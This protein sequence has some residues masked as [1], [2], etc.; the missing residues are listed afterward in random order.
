ML[1]LLL[2]KKTRNRQLVGL[3]LCLFS[4]RFNVLIM[5]DFG[6]VAQKPG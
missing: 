3:F 2:L 4:R 5:H 6:A 1:L